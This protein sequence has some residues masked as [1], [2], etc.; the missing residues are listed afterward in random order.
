MMLKIEHLQ[1]RLAVLQAFF[2]LHLVF[3]ND[4]INAVKSM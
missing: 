4:K 3:A 1:K 2:D